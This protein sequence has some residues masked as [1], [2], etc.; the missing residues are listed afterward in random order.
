MGVRLRHWEHHPLRRSR[1][2]LGLGQDEMKRKEK[3]PPGCAAARY[4]DRHGV[5]G[6][7]V[8]EPVEFT[9]NEELRRDIVQ[10]R[11]R[12]QNKRPSAKTS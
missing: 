9:L 1:V 3:A 6:E 4:Y 11:R 2:A 10:G 5:L 7:L 8:E 12:R